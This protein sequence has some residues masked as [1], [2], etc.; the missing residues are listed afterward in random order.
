MCVFGVE[1]AGS[2]GANTD[3][4]GNVNVKEVCEDARTASSEEEE[5]S[6]QRK[7]I[8][9]CDLMSSAGSLRPPHQP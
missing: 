4:K 7:L 6:Q 8:R 1:V 2:G 5:E 3:G 9:Q